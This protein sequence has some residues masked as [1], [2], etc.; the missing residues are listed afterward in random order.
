[1]Q[2]ITKRPDGNLDVAT[3]N[4]EP[5]MALQQYKDQC[6]INLIVKRFKRTGELTHLNNRRGFYGDLSDAPSFR[7]SMQLV[8]EAQQAFAELPSQIRKRFG[9][10]PA[11]LM[12]FIADKN[13]Y[14]EA[15]SLG[16]IDKK[17]GTTNESTI[18][19]TNEPNEPTNDVI[20]ETKPAKKTK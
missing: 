4:E 14:D 20:N 1:M 15:V 18:E 10:D 12:E 13:N 5:S 17:A 16:L 2:K 6:D 3:V 9:N 19:S 11:L 8:V 7:E